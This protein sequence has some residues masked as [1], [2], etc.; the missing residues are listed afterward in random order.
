MSATAMLPFSLD[1]REL[2]VDA[3]LVREILGAVVS[4][5]VPQADRDV[6]GVFLWNGQAVPLLDLNHCL[7]LN[8]ASDSAP[9]LRT[10]VGKIHG[11]LVGF[12]VSELSEVIAISNAEL[13][14]PRVHE[15]P[16]AAA[17][18]KREHVV[19]TVLDLPKLVAHVMHIKSVE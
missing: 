10:I 14:P 18:V 7:G 13:K 16:F 5:Q 1:G 12:C 8:S 4:I 17:E 2:L 11:E 9:M 6:P 3:S 19:S 15:L